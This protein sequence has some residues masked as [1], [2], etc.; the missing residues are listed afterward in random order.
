M[1]STTS[2]LVFDPFS[3]ASGDMIIGS[4]LSLGA[5]REL[6]VS[7]MESVADV[8]VSVS[9]EQRGLISA[10]RVRVMQKSSSHHNLRQITD[11]IKSAGLPRKITEDALGIMELV[12][13][14]EASVHGTS[15]DELHLHETGQ[16]DAI[17]D[18]MG[19]VVAFHS[20]RMADPLVFCMPVSVGGGFVNTAHGK[21]PVPAPA[22]LEILN[23]SGLIWKG[24]PVDHE[25]LTPTGAAILAYF[26]GKYGTS[27]TWYPLMTSSRTGYGA[28]SRAAD[29]P[30]VLRTVLG[31][32]DASLLTDHVDMLE[33]NVDDVTGEVLG[34]LIQELMNAG[35]LDVSIL[36]ATMK[37]GRSGALIKVICRPVDTQKLVHRIIAE[38]GSLG[39]RQVPVMHRFTIQ[40]T[41]IEVTVT[42]AGR[43]RRVPV[44]VACDN[45]GD[46]LNISAEFDDCRRIAQETG[47]PVK[48]IM[49]RAEEAARHQLENK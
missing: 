25:L 8:H 7:S 42:A 20:I 16:Q 38:T 43:S 10:A 11:Q 49:S 5:D 3:G 18:I 41:I 1:E 9:A 40:R 24:G 31:E 36:P 28:G 26:A 35:A 39:V 29:L 13:R 17:A 23:N 21:L 33:T 2:I 4:L 44:K 37:K 30:N 6:V 34:Y 15:L 12:G 45:R 32:R 19:A 27:G 48:D 47:R 22:T 14:S 46:I